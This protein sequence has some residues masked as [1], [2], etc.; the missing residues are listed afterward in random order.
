MQKEHDTDSYREKKLNS[1]KERKDEGKGSA[2][3]PSPQIKQPCHDAKNDGEKKTI[4]E[5]ARQ[6]G[7]NTRQEEGDKTCRKY[8]TERKKKGHEQEKKAR[9]KK[10]NMKQGKVHDTPHTRT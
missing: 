1:R 7:K 6:H 2:P 5:R 10:G 8:G 9:G 4:H 3:Y